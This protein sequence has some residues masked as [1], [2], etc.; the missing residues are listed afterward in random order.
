MKFR[1]PKYIIISIGYK[2][3]V[4]RIVQQNEQQFQ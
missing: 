1:E 3:G 4:L 2:D